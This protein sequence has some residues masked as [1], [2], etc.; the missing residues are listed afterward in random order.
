MCHIAGAS[1]DADAKYGQPPHLRESRQCVHGALDISR[2]RQRRFELTRLATALAE[3]AMVEGQGSKALRR[4]GSGIGTRSLFLDGGERTGGDGKRDRSAIRQE[5]V[6][7]KRHAVCLELDRLISHAP[8]SSMGSPAPCR[9]LSIVEERQQATPTTYL[10][11][12]SPADLAWLEP[13]TDNSRRIAL[14]IP[15]GMT[16]GIRSSES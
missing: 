7:H 1:A 4:E 3:V 10:S 11:P 5:E 14:T 15:R 2:L 12:V 9:L 8:T 6:A 16:N 13:E